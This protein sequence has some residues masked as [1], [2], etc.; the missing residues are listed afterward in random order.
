MIPCIKKII[1]NFNNKHF[2]E[3]KT[4]IISIVCLFFFIFNDMID[5]KFWGE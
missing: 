2:K 3:N 5:G 1:Y 4:I